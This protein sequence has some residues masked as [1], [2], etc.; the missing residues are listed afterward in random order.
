M[1]KKSSNKNKKNM[2]KTNNKGRIKE[3][4]SELKK[5]SYPTLSKTAKQTGIVITLILFFALV[6]FGVD[7]GLSKLYEILVSGLS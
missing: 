4:G 7:F 2:K 1:S 5:V 3:M 6:L